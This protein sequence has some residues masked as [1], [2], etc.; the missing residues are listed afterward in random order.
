MPN[1]WSLFG[2]QALLGVE[3]L[4][5]CAL[6]SC[7]TEPLSDRLALRPNPRQSRGTRLAL[8]GGQVVQSTSTAVG[9]H[10]PGLGEAVAEAIW[11]L[12]DHV[13]ILGLLYEFVLPFFHAVCCRFLLQSFQ[14]GLVFH[15]DLYQFSAALLSVQRF[16]VFL[17]WIIKVWFRVLH[18][19][20][21]FL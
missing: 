6:H 20:R 18:N 2:H 16:F 17:V 1:D 5:L 8:S 7:A 14:D 9:G 19:I 13:A 21:H 12:A 10:D 3:R 4:V 15:R 11:V